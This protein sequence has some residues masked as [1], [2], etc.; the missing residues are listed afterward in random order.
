M[1]N[2]WMV[3]PESTATG[4]GQEMKSGLFVY[5]C[6]K[7]RERHKINIKNKNEPGNTPRF[8]KNLLFQRLVT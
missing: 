6:R 5:A 4:R 1:N 8:T 7:C 2:M 3:S